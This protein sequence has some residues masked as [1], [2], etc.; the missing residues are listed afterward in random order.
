MVEAARAENVVSRELALDRFMMILR[1]AER[2]HTIKVDLE[3]DTDYFLAFAYAIGIRGKNDPYKLV[4]LHVRRELAIGWA[5]VEVE[6]HGSALHWLDWRKFLDGLL[7]KVATESEDDEDD[8]D[9]G[10]ATLAAA[11]AAAVADAE[12]IA[13]LREKIGGLTSALDIAKQAVRG[14]RMRA[15]EKQEELDAARADAEMLRANPIV[16]TVVQPPPQT[17]LDR[18]QAAVGVVLEHAPAP[19]Y[20]MLRDAAAIFMAAM[21]PADPIPT[22]IP[23]PPDPP[24]PANYPLAVPFDHELAEGRRRLVVMIAQYARREPVTPDPPPP[25]DRRIDLDDP[26]SGYI[27]HYDRNGH[28]DGYVK[29]WQ[30]RGRPKVWPLSTPIEDLP[31]VGGAP[32]PLSGR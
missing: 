10:A 27:Y 7:G 21:R 26:P 28:L 22:P 14:E 15:D 18:F 6:M 9:D 20:Q 29:S 5:R 25:I 30:R 4:K 16:V 2:L 8:N 24:P 31:V 32:R 17:D 3:K 11:A 13:S 19:M 1:H 23:D 12:E